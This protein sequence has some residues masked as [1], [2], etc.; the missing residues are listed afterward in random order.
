[1]RLSY[2]SIDT[3][4]TCPAKFRFRYEDRLPSK[5]SPA[6]SFGD[7]LHQAL[8]RFHDRPVPV[9]PALEELLEM[10]DGVWVSEG[11]ASEPEERSYREHA[12]QVLADYHRD[13]APAYRIPAALEHRFAIDV[14]RARTRATRVDPEEAT[15]LWRAL[16]SGR[17][18]VVERFDS[19]GRRFVV[20]CPNEVPV[21]AH[22]PLS[23][24]EEQAVGY[25]SLGHGD[26][27]IAYE[28]GL[29]RGTVAQL[30]ARARKKLGVATRA[31]LI[32]LWLTRRDGTS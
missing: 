13:N 15:R 11:Y 29:S 21:G 31:E 6:L 9:A 19:D 32:A 8:F 30:L 17:W 25:A 5:R 24:R 14:D 2:S 22:P 7:S 28:M 18:S 23:R 10:L 4:E 16:A 1:M 27:L 20:A 26:K 12:E 3:Y